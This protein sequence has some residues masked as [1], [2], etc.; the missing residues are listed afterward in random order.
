MGAESRRLMQRKV[1]ELIER[2]THKRRALHVGDQLSFVSKRVRKSIFE[3]VD[4]TDGNACCRDRLEP[5]ITRPS[6]QYLLEVRI[7]FVAMGHSIADCPVAG[8]VG[9]MICI[10]R[11][12][13]TPEESVGGRSDH[14]RSVGSGVLLVRRGARGGRSETLRME[15]GTEQPDDLMTHHEHSTVD[16]S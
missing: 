2:Q 14:D 13:S 8:V 10:Q 1:A 15:I 5:V 11:R 6:G 7:E 12:T 9:E 4:R 16:Q 3:A